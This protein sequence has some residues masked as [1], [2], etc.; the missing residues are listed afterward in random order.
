MLQILNI[1]GADLARFA[2]ELLFSWTYTF[3]CENND[4]RR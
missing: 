1:Y 4:N 3:L 2:L